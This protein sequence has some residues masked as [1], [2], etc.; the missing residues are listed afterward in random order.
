MGGSEH[1]TPQE[2]SKLTC[3]E[4][5]VA[6]GYIPNNMQSRGESNAPALVTRE[7]GFI[8]LQVARDCIPVQVNQ[9][10]CTDNNTWVQKLHL[11]VKKFG[12][13]NYKAARIPVPSGLN[14]PA[15]WQVLQNYDIPKLF[16]YL[17]F[18]FPLGVD[19][20]LFEFKSFTKNHSSAVKNPMAVE[21][22]FNT[23]VSKKAMFGPYYLKPFE[24]MHFSP[25][26]ARPKPDGG[27]RIIVDLS[28]PVG[29]SVNSCVPSN[30][31]DDV[32]FILKYPTIDQ[33]VERIKLVG[34]SALLYK[35]DLERAFRNLRVDPFDYPLLGLQWNTDVYVDVSVPFGLKFG[36]AACQMCT[37]ALTLTLRSQKLWLINYLDDYVG[38]APPALAN[39]H[40]LS[41]M[42]LLRFV[43][44][45]VNHTKVEEPAKVIT[46]LGIEINAETGT[47]KIPDQKINE[48]LK[49][50]R[51]WSRQKVASKN[52]LQKLVGKLIY[53]HRCVQPSRLFL[54]RI[55]TVLRN[56]PATGVKPLPD[57]FF[58]D[59][60]WFNK[61]LNIF[62]GQVNFYSQVQKHKEVWIDA[63]LMQ[64][65]AKYENYVYSSDIP[66]EL[67]NI[68]SI[69]HFEAANVLAAIRTWFSDWKNATVTVWCDNLAVV[70]AFTNHKIRDP[71]LMAIVR[72]VWL[73]CAA[74]NI[75]LVVKHI[76]G[77][78]NIFADILSRWPFFHNKDMYQVRLL[79]L[80]Q[81]EQ[82]SPVTLMPDFS[83]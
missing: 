64:V 56:T 37:D 47:L 67:K 58:R 23:E 50:C 7:F 38:V 80:C 9:L 16:Q 27:T 41:L 11:Q 53:I 42:N 40:F 57:M 34:P 70:N 22:Y 52:Q 24:K 4:Y 19:Y 48:I 31:Y 78:D 1:I 8:P 75:K 66:Q 5:E 12:L 49:L 61:F 6:D 69:V 74:F 68:G 15:W 30:V 20:S 10:E 33:V 3:T 14:I 62:N 45:P 51:F 44:L 76:K 82:V 26:M 32:P 63:S 17:Q 81:W 79:K 2:V 65:G 43:G 71:L 13:P 28:W 35:V 36:A 83:I 39:S 59:I 55:L 46:C 21:K 60:T 77:I 29:A 73:Y 25:L 18:G 54:N 72:S